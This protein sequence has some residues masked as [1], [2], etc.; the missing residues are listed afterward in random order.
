MYLRKIVFVFL[1]VISTVVYAEELTQEKK[2]LIVEL[3]EITGGA[4]LGE[5]FASHI[6]QNMNQM[7][8]RANPSIPE[9]AFQ[10]VEE[11]TISAFR[12]AMAPGGSF[13]ESMFP[14]YNKYYTTDDL[15]GL[16]V[17]YKTPLGKKTIEVMPLLTQ[18]S[19]QVGQNWGAEIS[20][21]VGQ[22]I[23]AKLEAEGIELN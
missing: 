22:K 4:K 14:I 21:E 13:M 1:F 20:Q 16:I 15:K 8:R 19:M 3:N 17:F 12:E 10:I 18:E 7:I 23:Q 5:M 9:R 11:E 6:M 2:D